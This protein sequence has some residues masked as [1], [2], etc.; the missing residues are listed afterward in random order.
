[1]KKILVL[2]VLG[3]IMFTGCAYRAGYQAGLREAAYQAPGTEV[4]KAPADSVKALVPPDT[5]KVSPVDTVGVKTKKAAAVVPS[6][7]Q[8]PPDT[9][10]REARIESKVSKLS[11][12]DVLE[13]E[14]LPPTVWRLEI[15]SW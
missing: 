4:R 11:A 9:T 13:L 12:L 8:P 3:A 2:V 7:A 6:I 5:I 14:V 10:R 1:M 15:S